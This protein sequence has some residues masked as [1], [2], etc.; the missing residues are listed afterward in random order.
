MCILVFGVGPVCAH[1]G[2]LKEKVPDLCYRC[3][4]KLK[5]RLLSSNVHFPFKEGKC[6]ACH[7]SHAS[8]MK[9]PAQGRDKAPVSWLSSGNKECAETEICAQGLKERR[10]H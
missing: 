10:L 6:T 7:S 2:D 4:L 5:D 9:R 3:H 8:G 1:Q